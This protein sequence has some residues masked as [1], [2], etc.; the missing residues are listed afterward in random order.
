VF[1]TE[2]KEAHRLQF[3]D[4]SSQASTF[5]DPRLPR[6]PPGWRLVQEIDRKH[7]LR[8]FENTDTGEI[9]DMDPRLTTEALMERGVKLETFTLI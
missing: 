3:Y 2:V 1:R 8:K 7:S 4:T 5:E 6:L 9:T